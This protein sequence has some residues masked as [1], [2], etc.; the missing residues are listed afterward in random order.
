MN[1]DKQTIVR[2][3]LLI[4]FCVRSGIAVFWVFYR[5]AY[6]AGGEN[7]TG[8]SPCAGS[9]NFLKEFFNLKSKDKRFDDILGYFDG[10]T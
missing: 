4:L 6:A 1:I 3:V 8:P 5:F 2:Q 10:E 7:D 9:W